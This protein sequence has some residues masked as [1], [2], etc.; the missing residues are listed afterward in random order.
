MEAIQFCT[1]CTDCS[2]VWATLVAVVRDAVDA[3]PTRDKINLVV[4]KGGRRKERFLLILFSHVRQYSFLKNV[5]YYTNI[6]PLTVIF[7]IKAN[8]CKIIIFTK[9]TFHLCCN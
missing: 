3:I 7:L 2:V 9:V 4:K 6:F 5:M 8:I 1:D